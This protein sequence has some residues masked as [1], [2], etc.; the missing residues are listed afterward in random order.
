MKTKPIIEFINK[1]HN[2]LFNWFALQKILETLHKKYTGKTV[3]III[4]SNAMSKKEIETVYALRKALNNLPVADVT[5][6]IISQMVTTKSNDEFLDKIDTY[7]R[8]F[9]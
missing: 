6:N 4:Y 5:E 3:P 9:K 1:N 8:R 7:L 2:E